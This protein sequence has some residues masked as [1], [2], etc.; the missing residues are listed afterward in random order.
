MTIHRDGALAVAIH[1]HVRFAFPLGKEPA[2]ARSPVA[3]LAQ[4][5]REHGSECLRHV[6]GSCAIAIVDS[7]TASGLL[8]VDRLGVRAMC[9]ATP[10]KQLVF[11]STAGSVAAHPAVGA[12]LNRQGVFNYLYCHVVPSP[13]TI[14]QGVRKLLP[15]ECIMFSHGALDKRFYWEL[16]YDDDHARSVG[17][18]EA[19]FQRL[20]RAAIERSLDGDG[21]VGAFL[22]GGTDSSTVAGLLTELRGTPAKTYSIG[23]ATQGFDEIEYARITSPRR[24]STT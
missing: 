3:R 14:Y 13:G 21:A 9:Y 17:E 24:E 18:L 15:G 7:N 20:L 5:Y 2:T 12:A 22:S 23:F 6:R 8:A 1:G 4:L 16:P 19:D 11:G 10:P